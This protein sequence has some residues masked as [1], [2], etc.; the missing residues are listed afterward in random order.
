[1]RAAKLILVLVAL[2]SLSTI[3][4]TTRAATTELHILNWQGYGSDEAWAVKQ[5]EDAHGVKIVH[6]YFTSL[7]EMLTKLRTSP[8][9][10]DAV[11][12]NI[13][14]LKPALD[15]KLIQSIDQ[16]KITVWDSLAPSLRD[17]P[18]LRQGTKDLYAVPWTWGATGLVY[19][20]KDFP[21]GFDSIEVLWDPKYAGQI[22]M[23]DSYED[24]FLFAALRAGIKQPYQNLTPE[25]LATIRKN[26]AALTP[27]V[28][29]YWQ[30]EDEFN[31]LF[32]SSEIK[33]GVYWS[34]SASRAANVSKLP[35][36]FVVPKEGAEGWVDSW[37][38][39]AN[40]PNAA[41]ATEW[42]NFMSSPEFFL[43]WDK[44]AGA[45]VPAN[46]KTFDQLPKE[47]FTRVVFG[48][49]QNVSRLV[50]ASF[51]PEKTRNDLLQVW[52]EAKLSGAK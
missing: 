1:M 42:I 30:S 2:I 13:A 17:L 4:R 35:I 41:M 9:T 50:F 15:D 18:E 43:E 16:S 38:I 14:Y 7:D 51:L 31:R 20:T 39:A 37:T 29:A 10:Y 25:N 6:D 8:G 33:I 48:D 49:A 12:I 11:Q 44:V 36:K 26:L 32:A 5:F 28:K 52:Q 24:A 23:S 34:G 22:G 21:N 47:S 40:A 27:N 3:G 19:N 46:S 45:P